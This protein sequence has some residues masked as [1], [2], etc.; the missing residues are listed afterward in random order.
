MTV[1]IIF[2][3]QPERMITVRHMP[4]SQRELILAICAYWHDK[5]MPFCITE[6]LR[7]EKPQKIF[8]S[9]I[10]LEGEKDESE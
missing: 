5:E 3:S 6:V 4:K 8:Y 2:V 10:W 1:E 9:V 7:F